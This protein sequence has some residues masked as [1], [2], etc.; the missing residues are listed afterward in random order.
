MNI[1]AFDASTEVCSVALA[2]DDSVYERSCDTPKSHAKVLLPLIEALQQEA[3]LSVKKLNAIAVTCGPGSFTGIRI[4]LSIA[5]GLSYGAQLPIIGLNTLQVLAMNVAHD[6]DAEALVVSALDARM[7]EVYGAGFRIE[8]ALPVEVFTS[9][10]STP[11]QFTQSLRAAYPR[12]PLVGVGHGWAIADM[13]TVNPAD[14]RADA[15]P[16]AR[17]MLALA[18]AQLT[19]RGLADFPIAE[20]EPIYLRN[21]VSWQKRRRIRQS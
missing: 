21:E 10:V 19:A 14:L 13:A 2:T 18:K 9:R 17:D 5:Q 20:I 3:G 15:K 16:R 8:N 7:G 6:L 11:Q 1:L 4:G 12:S